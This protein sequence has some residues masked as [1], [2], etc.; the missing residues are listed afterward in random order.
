MPFK[1]LAFFAV[2]AA[3]IAV[4]CLVAFTGK[5]GSVDGIVVRKGAASIDIAEQTGPWN[6]FEV[7]K[8]VAPMQSWVVARSRVGNSAGVVLGATLVPAG[9]STNVN[10]ALDPKLAMVNT[11]VV[12]MLAD[13]GRRGVLEPSAVAAAG[14]G[15]M[16]GGGMGGAQQS[17]QGAGDSTPATPTADKPLISGGVPVAVTVRETFRNGAPGVVQRAVAP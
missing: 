6:T 5:A 9:T 10:I 7:S 13:R 15:G 16:G 12:S 11:F 4:L 17:S 3:E 1:R 2:L 8:V 14:G